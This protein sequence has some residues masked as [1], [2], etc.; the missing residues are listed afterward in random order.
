[1]TKR[2]I[3]NILLVEEADEKTCEEIEEE[4]MREAET[5]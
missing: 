4:I 1:M 2:C 3:L 5:S